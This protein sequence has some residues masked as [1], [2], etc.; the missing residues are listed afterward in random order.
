MKALEFPVGEIEPQTDVMRVQVRGREVTMTTLW[1]CPEFGN[2]IP[3]RSWTVVCGGKQRGPAGTVGF[4]SSPEDFVQTL[5][6]T[7]E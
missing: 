2:L 7:W 1:K 6:R 5:R 4:T 3:I